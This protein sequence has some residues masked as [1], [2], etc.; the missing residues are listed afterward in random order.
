MADSFMG[1]LRGYTK[2]EE[3][4]AC[5]GFLIENVDQINATAY[6]WNFTN[7]DEEVKEIWEQGLE[8]DIVIYNATE[9]VSQLMGPSWLYCSIGLYYSGEQF[10]IKQL[11]FKNSTDWVLSFLQNFLSKVIIIN[12]TYERFLEAMTINDVNVMAFNLGKLLDQ[13]MNF[14]MIVYTETEDPDLDWG[15]TYQ[16]Y[17]PPNE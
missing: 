13:F 17:V 15:D 6:A 12:R 10:Y 16:P 8:P 5:I 2:V 11:Q 3:M 7:E 14:D 1:G 4:G 9:A